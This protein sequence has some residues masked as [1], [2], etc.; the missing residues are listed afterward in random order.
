M[1]LI[2]TTFFFFFSLYFFSQD[3]LLGGKLWAGTS[4]N[5]KINKKTSL[6]IDDLHSIT[7]STNR[8]SFN[9]V[10]VGLSRKLSKKT[11][12][13][14]SYA[15]GIYNWSNSYKTLGIEPTANNL[16]GIHRFGLDA[17][18][19]FRITKRLRVKHTL[20]IQYYTKALNKYQIRSIY[21][22]KIYYYKK[23]NPLSFSPFL[24]PMIYYYNGGVP[25]LYKDDNNKITHYKSSN[26]FHRFRIKTGVKLKPI[27]S[28]SNFS[29]ILY[30][31]MQNEFNFSNSKTPINTIE[32]N[33]TTYLEPTIKAKTINPFNNYNVIGLHLIYSLKK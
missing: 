15:L 32:N 16:A 26:G 9:Q 6:N 24:E 23:N 29:I 11:K 4:I 1:K 31:M 30:Y 12:I 10:S 7:T 13:K 5:Y 18:N 14:A 3:L 8:F 33:S 2:S 22:F 27:E 21:R 28:L 20:S 17:S 25:V 19:K